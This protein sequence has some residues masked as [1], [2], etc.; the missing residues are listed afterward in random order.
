MAFTGSDWA[1]VAPSVPDLY[2]ACPVFADAFD[3]ACAHLD[4]HLT[5][6][7]REVL[8]PGGLGEADDALLAGA[9]LAV[10]IALFRLVTS[11]G[12]TAD[13]VTGHD[14]GALTAAHAAGALSVADAA[15]LAVVPRSQRAAE[16]AGLTFGP[17]TLTL[18]SA[19]DG[20]AVT[21]DDLGADA[22]WTARP[23][24]AFPDPVTWAGA[25]GAV[26][27][28]VTDLT[29]PAAAATSLAGAAARGAAVDWQAFF[30]GTAPR[31][32][33]LPTYA[34]QRKRY[35]LSPTAGPDERK[36][37]K[38]MSEE[39]SRKDVVLEYFSRLNAGDVDS[40]LKLFTEDAWVE[41]PVGQPARRGQ[42]ELREYYLVTMKEAQIQDEVDMVVAAQDGSHVMASVRADLINVQD[43]DR[44][45]ITINVILAFEVTLAGFING[46]R[47]FWGFSDIT[48]PT[49]PALS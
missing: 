47:A 21:V 43:P 8:A 29:G 18:L 28:P 22:Y 30:A 26:V 16:A 49:R 39:N 11:W 34:F 23:H 10:G 19:G 46:I 45:R 33:D 3:E 32:V 27:V 7:P 44:T 36:V 31:P 25:D 4:A 1:A 35:W 20:A 13:A 15:R 17:L 2:E 24:P 14:L 38:L 6:S 9:E 5:R 40:M 37:E 42:R 48:D 41:D 12:L